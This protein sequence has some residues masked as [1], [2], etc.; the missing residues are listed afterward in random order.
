MKKIFI[1]SP[2]TL[3]DTGENVRNQIL[4]A[5]QLMTAGYT[6]FIPLL[7]HFQHLV[8]PRPYDDWLANDLEWLPVC[9]ALLRLP[10]ES[11]GADLEVA[12]AIELGIP[13]YYSI[14]D[15]IKIDSKQ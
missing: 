2:Y 1:S 15:I 8:C 12:K 4:A 14:D 6:S 13:V 3:G 7:S 9:N 10:G 5:D 11:A